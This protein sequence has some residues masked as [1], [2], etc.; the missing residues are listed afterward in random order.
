MS[1][2]TSSYFNPSVKKKGHLHRPIHIA[3]DIN[4]QHIW[5]EENLL[6]RSTQLTQNDFAPNDK[7]PLSEIGALCE[8][9]YYLGSLEGRDCVAWPISADNDE[10][11][12]YKSTN[13]YKLLLMCDDNIFNLL[14]RAMQIVM[15]ARNH[16]YCGACGGKT[17]DIESEDERRKYCSS[18]NLGVYPRIS[19]C[20]IVLVIKEDKLLLANNVNH[21]QN[22]YSALAGFVEPGETVEECLRRE[23]MEEVGLYVDGLE[24]F[25][26]Q[27]W[28]FPHQLMLGFFAR[29]IKGD[30]KINRDELNDARWY[31]YRK[32]PE[33]LPGTYSIAGKLI[34][35]AVK[36]LNSLKSINK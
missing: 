10:L 17:I 21:P 7:H 26:S 13:L 28:P 29:H 15:W 4:R 35:S 1:Q 36:N 19:P 3:V 16:V 27:S 24:Y 25:G 14:G 30:I 18:C 22:M 23:I 2:I 31:D 33:L 20:V 34:N 9:N 6:N 12:G 32:L 5:I 11:M 8:D